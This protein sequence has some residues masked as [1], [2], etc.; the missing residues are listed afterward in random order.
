MK[1]PMSFVQMLRELECVKFKTSPAV[2]MAVFSGRLGSRGLT[3][4]HFKEAS[5]MSCLEDGSTNSSRERVKSCTDRHFVKEN[6]PQRVNLVTC[7]GSEQHTSGANVPP[8]CATDVQPPLITQSGSTIQSPNAI[9]QPL[10][11][12]SEFPIQKLSTETSLSA[13]KDSTLMAL[14]LVRPAVSSEVAARAHDNASQRRD[15]L[16]EL[17]TATMAEVFS[18]FDVTPPASN[19]PTSQEGATGT[20]FLLNKLLQQ[21]LSDLARR[22]A[23]SPSEFVELVR[24][25]TMS[26]YRPNK[27]MVPTVL[28]NVCKGYSHLDLLQRIVQ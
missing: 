25:Q 17:Q 20:E 13:T 5:E 21:A 11:I 12:Q 3:V 14:K 18:R 26:D 15:L 9:Q 19:C 16:R 7:E 4:M 10:T 2:L 8:I 27:N 24:G 22:S 1:S 6:L 28:E 23:L